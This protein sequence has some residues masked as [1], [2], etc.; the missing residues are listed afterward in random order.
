MNFCTA[1]SVYVTPSKILR[2]KVWKPGSSDSLVILIT[3]AHNTQSLRVKL[4]ALKFYCKTCKAVHSIIYSYL[5]IFYLTTLF[6]WLF[7]RLYSVVW[8][9]VWLMM[10][11]KGCGRKRSWPNLKVLY[12]NFHGGTGKTSTASVRTESRFE[13]LTSRMRSKSANHSTTTF[14][15]VHNKEIFMT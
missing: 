14:R 5:I 11:W 9:G 10:N 3:P 4:S 1:Y 8:K 2:I 13:F 7:V 6:Q 12:R 15:A